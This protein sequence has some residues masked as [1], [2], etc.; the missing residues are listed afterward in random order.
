MLLDNL[1]SSFKQSIGRLT[2]F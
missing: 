1:Q 2:H